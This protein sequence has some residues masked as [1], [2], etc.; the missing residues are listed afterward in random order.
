MFGDRSILVRLSNYIPFEVFFLILEN[1][2]QNY[3]DSI[4]CNAI[5]YDGRRNERS[6]LQLVREKA[7]CNR[8]KG[9]NFFFILLCR[10]SIFGCRPANYFNRIFG[11]SIEKKTDCWKISVWSLRYKYFR[12]RSSCFFCRSLK[13]KLV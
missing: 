4:M 11:S 9:G 6:N 3:H 13:A 7:W 8:N 12:F 5:A 10:S 1:E 2:Q